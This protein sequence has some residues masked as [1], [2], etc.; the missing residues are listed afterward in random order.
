MHIANILKNLGLSDNEALVYIA[1]LEAGVAS[2][3]EIAKKAKIKRTTAYSVLNDLVKKGFVHT[4]TER[5]KTRFTAVS[6]KQMADRFEEYRREL[7][8]ALPSLEAMYNK[9]QVKPKV[10]L[11]SGVEGIHDL[12]ED[13]VREKPDSVLGYHTDAVFTIDADMPSV[14]ARL[15]AQHHIRAR[16]IVPKHPKWMYHKSRDKE[17]MADTV[18]LPPD[19]F[20]PS[21]EVLIYGRKVA[22]VSHADAMGLVIENAPIADA[23]RQA[24]ELAWFQAK[25]IAQG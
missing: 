17:Q 24:Y 6:P 3:Q 12:Y 19:L 1:S 9:S 21:V 4:T 14:Y 10:V 5:G 2:A 8:G 13:T 20:N 23:M 11:Y 22:F 16:R 15:R 25:T 18:M 7:V